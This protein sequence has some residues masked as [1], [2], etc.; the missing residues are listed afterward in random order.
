VPQTDPAEFEIRRYRPGDETR[1]IDLFERTFGRTMGPSESARHWEWE[2]RDRPGAQIAILLAESGGKLAAQYAVVPLTLR[3]DGRDCAAALS[4]DTATASEFRGRGLFP[5]LATQLYSELAEENFAAVFGFPNRQ[6]A[7]SFFTKLGWLE[8][9]PFPLL[10]K[11]LRGGVRKW[12]ESKGA[13]G[14]LV[15]PV[16]EAASALIRRAPRRIPPTLVFEEVRRF[17]D[18]S[19]ELWERASAGKRCVVVRDRRYLDWRYVQ[20]PESEYRIHVV[21]ESGRLV[22]MVVTLVRDRHTLRG[23]FLMDLLC[24]ESRPDVARALV[25]RAEVAMAGSGAQVLS[26][27]M[28]PGGVG[29]RALRGAAFFPVPRRVFP[30]EIHFGVRALAPGTNADVLREPSNWYITWGDSDIV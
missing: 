23:G 13:T 15:S 22:G 24:E 21:R 5:K 25:S 8:L 17:P 28:Y 1:I 3:I 29:H 11:P 20:R 30:Q 12:L 2:F 18:D 14:R 9:A 19:D 6:S 27:L 7:P 10:F 4:L 16:A 26:A